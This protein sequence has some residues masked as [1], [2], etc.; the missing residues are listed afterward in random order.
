VIIASQAKTGDIIPG[1]N[2]RNFSP[3]F[4]L[5]VAQRLLE[6]HYTVT[7]DATADKIEIKALTR[8]FMFL[9]TITRLLNQRLKMRRD[10][11]VPNLRFPVG[12]GHLIQCDADRAIFTAQMASDGVGDIRGQCGFLFVIQVTGKTFDVYMRHGG[13]LIVSL[14]TIIFPAA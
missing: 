4:R 1:R 11:C 14:K 7:A 10:L 6:R 3:E 13:L 9:Q 12:F 2:R 5:D 8:A